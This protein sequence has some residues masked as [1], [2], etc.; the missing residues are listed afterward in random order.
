LITFEVADLVEQQALQRRLPITGKSWLLFVFRVL[1]RDDHILAMVV[2]V[3]LQYF[4]NCCQYELRST[5]C[6][7][8]PDCLLQYILFDECSSDHEFSIGC[9]SFRNCKWKPLLVVACQQNV[10]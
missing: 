6:L 4:W 10:D 2:D 5:C 3:F 1:F 7:R 8:H 9:W